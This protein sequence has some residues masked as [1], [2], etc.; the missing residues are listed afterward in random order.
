MKTKLT[1]KPG[2]AYRDKRSG[3]LHSEVVTSKPH[4]FELI[5]L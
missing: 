1:A 3:K 4:L 5:E 2:Y